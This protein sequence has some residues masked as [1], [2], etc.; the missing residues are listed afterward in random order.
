[1]THMDLPTWEECISKAWGCIKTQPDLSNRYLAMA[2]ELRKADLV[3]IKEWN[4]IRDGQGG[5]DNT[6]LT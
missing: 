2:A 1:M 4:R 6:V 5:T 3:T